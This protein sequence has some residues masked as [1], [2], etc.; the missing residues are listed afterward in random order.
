[1]HSYVRTRSLTALRLEP[2]D[3]LPIDLGDV[4]GETTRVAGSSAAL[5]GWLTGRTD[6]ADLRCDGP[7]P[8]LPTW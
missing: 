1:M 6:G 5:A 2:D 7:L 4:T 8:D 3:G